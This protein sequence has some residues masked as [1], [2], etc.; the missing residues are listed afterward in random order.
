MDGGMPKD[1]R[2]DGFRLKEGGFWV[3]VRKSLE[4]L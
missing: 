3:D 4:D 1:P 2:G